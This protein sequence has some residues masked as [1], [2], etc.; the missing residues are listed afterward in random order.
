MGSALLGKDVVTKAEYIF[1][2]GIYK[3][4]SNLY[5][6]F[7][8]NPLYIYGIMQSFL[9]LIKLLYIGTY[10][11]FFMVYYLFFYLIS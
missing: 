6:Y 10:S 1:L 7:V 5:F 4:Y 2:K 3:L 11:V 9:A 8:R